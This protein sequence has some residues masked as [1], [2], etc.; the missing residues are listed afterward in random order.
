MMKNENK[1]NA[2]GLKQYSVIFRSIHLFCLRCQYGYNASVRNMKRPYSLG[3]GKEPDNYTHVYRLD[4]Q[5]KHNWFR[6]FRLSLL[7]TTKDVLK[8]GFMH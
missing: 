8:K 6:S 4:I 2:N 1:P 7:S 3:L 5:F